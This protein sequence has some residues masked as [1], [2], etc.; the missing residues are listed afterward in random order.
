MTSFQTAR[1]IIMNVTTL[2]RV[3]ACATAVACLS[4]FVRAAS[5][6]KPSPPS[7]DVVQ[8]VLESEEDASNSSVDRRTTLKPEARPLSDPDQMWWQAGYT[9]SGKQWRSY[10]TNLPDSEDSK[11]LDEY[12]NLRAELKDQPH[13]QWKLAN[14][15]RKN[16]ML[17]QERVHLIR[18][19]AMRDSSANRD[20]VYERLGC[21]KIGDAWVSPKERQDEIRLKSEIENSHKHWGAKLESL[22]HRLA[23]TPKQRVQAEKALHEIEDPTAVPAI[24]SS[25]CMTNQFLAEYGITTLGQ[26]PQFQ[27]SRALA[28]Q[29]LFSPWKPVRVKA[30]AL[31]KR[32]KLEEFAPDLLMVL[33]SPIRA[34]RQVT[35]QKIPVRNGEDISGFRMNWDYVWIDE[36]HD[37]IRVG[38]RRLFPIS[39]GGNYERNSFDGRVRNAATLQPTGPLSMGI[40]LL[41]LLD[42]AEQLDRSADQINQVREDTNERVGKVLSEVTDQTMS[43]VPKIWWTWWA[44]FSNSPNQKSVVLV[45]ERKTQPNI[46]SLS[47]MPRHACLVAGTPIWTE[48]GFVAIEQIQPGDRVLSKEIESGQLTYKPVLQTTVREPTPVLNFQLG[49]DSINASPGHHFWVSGEGWTKTRQLSSQQP[50]HTV[51]GMQRIVKIEDQGRVERVYNLV[52]ADFHTYFVGK[53]MMLSHDVLSP[54]LTNVKIPGLAVQ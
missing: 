17:D 42:Q 50:M 26:I 48:R 24:V 23:G 31:L 54:E 1:G 25:F 51:T 36:S 15:C 30:I 18:V 53:S 28:G 41:E 10:E 52:V 21:Q 43:A 45:D 6:V 34:G 27:A 19:L 4:E 14:W 47:L 35:T 33:S 3:I 11:K 37:T 8:L 49:E 20:A 40:A 46:P 44:D 2:F 38:I 13:G 39:V 16:G 12:R 7:T 22:A 5:K 9:Q 29:A 32:R